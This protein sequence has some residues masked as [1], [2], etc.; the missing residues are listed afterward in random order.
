MIIIDAFSFKTK[1]KKGSISTARIT[2]N[3]LSAERSNAKELKKKILKNQ[4]K[5]G[6]QISCECAIPS[7]ILSCASVLEILFIISTA[8]WAS[9]L[10]LVDCR[11][12][13]VEF[14]VRLLIVSEGE[15]VRRWITRKFITINWF[16]S[17]VCDLASHPKLQCSSVF[18]CLF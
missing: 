6:K 9:T 14:I 13:S 17:S 10:Y 2:L 15:I 5:Q 18:S 8:S 12:I 3:K 1:Q 16:V 11:R 7:W 4:T